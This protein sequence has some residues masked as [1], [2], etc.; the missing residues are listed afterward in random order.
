[1][2]L[3]NP[4]L[5]NQKRQKFKKLIGEFGDVFALSKMELEGTHILEYDIHVKQNA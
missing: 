3:E 5:T 1:L 4:D 2:K